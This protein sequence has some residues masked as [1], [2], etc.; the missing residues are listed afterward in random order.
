MRQVSPER[1]RKLATLGL[2][3]LVGYAVFRWHLSLLTT[4][5]S[6][7]HLVAEGFVF[8]STLGP[9]FTFALS[10][11]VLIVLA[12]AFLSVV[13]SRYEKYVASLAIAAGVLA[14]FLQVL[15]VDLRLVFN[16]FP[17]ITLIAV[18]LAFRVRSHAP[19]L[20]VVASLYFAAATHKLINFPKLLTYIPETI[21]ARLPQGLLLHAPEFAAWLP[22]VLSFI[23]IPLEY[24]MAICLLVP[25]LRIFGFALALVFHTLVSSFTND[26]DGL[27]MVGLF[28]LYAHGLQFL[29]FAS[30]PV[31]LGRWSLALVASLIAWAGITHPDLVGLRY[32]IAFYLP[33][34]GLVFLILWPRSER[35]RLASWR[36]D[37]PRRKWVVAWGACLFLWCAY[38][39]MIGY[40]NQQYGWAMMS[41]AH[42]G[43]E[44][45]CIV[46]SPTSCAERW[47][48]E[49]QV[50]IFRSSS[51][52]VFAS[53]QSS[54]LDQVKRHLQSR[55]AVESSAVGSLQ[56]VNGVRVCR[57]DRL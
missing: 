9:W 33:I 6:G 57:L 28:V 12:F 13:I 32:A 34:A 41:G 15:T 11:I 52:W 44:V 18:G 10:W 3:V 8:F 56:I 45:R 21:A 54:H 46:S 16:Y 24:S 47:Y 43:R 40:Q 26:A 20:I 1:L 30:R 31:D 55:C 17:S 35:E 48:F 2:V 22:K 42:L 25:R 49:P 38:P 23:V 51:E 4:G 36:L 29:Y 50:K 27:S 37:L 19:L 7:P 5:L 39:A 14:L 53:G